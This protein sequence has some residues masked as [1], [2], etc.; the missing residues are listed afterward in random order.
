L[1]GVLPSAALATS[2]QGCHFTVA[3]AGFPEAE[4]PAP[5][6]GELQRVFGLMQPDTVS[7]TTARTT[8]AKRRPTADPL[9]VRV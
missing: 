4:L 9:P 7:A 8:T 5:D 6:V 3:V 1:A 2:G